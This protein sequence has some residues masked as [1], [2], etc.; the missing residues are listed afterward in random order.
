MPEKIS[1]RTI[2]LL[3][4]VVAFVTYVISSRT[5]GDLLRNVPLF[6]GLAALPVAGYVLLKWK[7][8][9]VE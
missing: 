6:L 8:I 4:V 5:P 7:K 3:F 2:T 9:I 1:P